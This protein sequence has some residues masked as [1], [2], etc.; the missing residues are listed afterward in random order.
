MDRIFNPTTYTVTCIS[1]IRFTLKNPKG[2]VNGRTRSSLVLPLSG[3]ILYTL[4]NYAFEIK[5]GDLLYLPKSS[6]YSYHLLDSNCEIMKIEFDFSEQYDGGHFSCKYKDNVSKKSVSTE[7]Y[8][9]KF[10][11]VITGYESHSPV[12][13]LGALSEIC[14]MLSLF[15][16]QA[17][18]QK[19]PVDV[20]IAYIEERKLENF[21][22]DDAAR[23]CSLSPTHFRRLFKEKTGVSPIKYKN[24][25]I[26]QKAKNLLRST[27]MNVGEIAL[28]LGFYDIYSFSRFFKRYTSISPETFRKNE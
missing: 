20:G 26:I 12:R 21:H 3:R 25:L 13:R 14:D 18:E 24:L 1:A 4:D 19:S 22:I 2:A 9:I 6:T 10:H 17:T 27:S 11:R 23:A 28:A 16:S 15:A 8:I 5:R 7:E